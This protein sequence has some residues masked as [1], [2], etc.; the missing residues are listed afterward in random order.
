MSKIRNKLLFILAIIAT[1]GFGGAFLYNAYLFV[2]YQIDARSII[3]DQAAIQ[4]IFAEQL[5]FVMANPSGGTPAQLPG[6]S[7]AQ[8][9]EEFIS[10]LSI[11]REMTGNQDIIAYLHIEGTN[12]SN[13]VL[14]Y[15]DNFFY[16]RH[17]VHRASNV[18]GSLFLDYA[19]SPDFSDR[20]SI[21]YGHNMRNGT[22]FH[23]LRHFV[24]FD[25]FRANRYIT[26]I[27]DE[28]LLTYEVFAAFS[29]RIYFEYIQVSFHDDDD[30]LSLL[31]ELQSRS[32]H[33]SDISLS[34]SD[35]ILILS[36][37]TNTAQDMRFVVAAVLQHTQYIV[38]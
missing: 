9:Q 15:S 33:N 5:E 21:I 35:R 12:I 32:I 18:N 27:T 24:D 38:N 7:D 13:V 1:I 19:N 25:Y 22:M 10:P 3:E 6:T 11:V 14:Q 8:A 16:L 23:D 29:A 2:R 30:F 31:N 26:V 28:K 37:C 36:T 4:N 20:N 17:D 34:A